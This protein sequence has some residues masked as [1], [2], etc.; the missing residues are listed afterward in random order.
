MQGSRPDERLGAA[1]SFVRQGAVFAD[2]GTDHA[3]LPIFLLKSGRITRAVAAD[4]NEGPLKRARDNAEAEGLSS[5]IDFRLADGLSGMESLGLTD[6]AIC[7]MGGELIA[8]IIDRA[9]FVRNAQI[10]LILQPMTRVAILRRYLAREGFEVKEEKIMQAAGRIYVCLAA[11][12]TGKPYELSA[13]EEECG[14][15][16]LLRAPTALERGFVEQRLAA[17]KKKLCGMQSGGLD[18]EETAS[19][20]ALVSEYEH[21]LEVNAP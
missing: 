15:T 18:G 5:L 4:I 14:Q 6:I 8:S 20:A 7:G 21:Y 16:L 2:I 3:H 11:S 10:R 1:A 9:P 17:V 19:L 13:A 12:Y